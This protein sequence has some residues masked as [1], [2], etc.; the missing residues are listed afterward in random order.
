MNETV[1]A[2]G[3]VIVMLS[4][5]FKLGTAARVIERMAPS[6]RLTRLGLGNIDL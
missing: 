6:V 1:Q 2:T 3:Q 5:Q 4:L